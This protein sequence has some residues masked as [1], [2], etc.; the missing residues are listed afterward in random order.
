MF[1]R[2]VTVFGIPLSTVEQLRELV[3]VS[4]SD[5]G[6]QMQGMLSECALKPV[7]PM[8]LASAGFVS[9]YGQG[10]EALFQHLRADGIEAIVLTVGS[11]SRLLPPAAVNK[12]LADKIAKIEQSE[13]RKPGGRER[14]R[15]KDDLIAEMLPRAFVKPGRTH[16]YIDLRRCLVVVD[17]GSRKAAE[18]AASEVR[19]ALG[20]FPALPTNCEVAPRSVLTGW[21]AGEPLPA[22]WA[23]GEECELRD[24]M[25]GGG[26]VRMGKQELQGEEVRQCLEAGKQVTRLAI[27][28]EDRITAVVYEDMTLHKVKIL[29]GAMDS[30]EQADN[31]NLAAELDARM[32]LNIAEIGLLIDDLQVAFK[33]SKTE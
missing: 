28:R 19:R 9:P 22:G 12:A 11:E 16:L 26:V 10:S 7:G 31:E 4:G 15:L 8:E 33:W 13:G 1:Y 24:P 2:N 23:L 3:Q 21:I 17:A 5:S 27:V 18:N 20:S 32:F 14:K 29:D 25:D 30:L 6:S